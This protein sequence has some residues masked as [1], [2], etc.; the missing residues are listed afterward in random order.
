MKILVVTKKTQGVRKGDCCWCKEG[1]LVKFGFECDRDNENIDGTCGCK[2]SM[3]GIECHKAT[4]TMKVID[5]DISEDDYI[6]RIKDSLVK[7]GWGGIG[8][9]TLALAI[10]DAKELSRLANTFDVGDII[11]K[12]GDIFQERTKKRKEV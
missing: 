5:M 1:E 2:R 7:A 4:T 9:D 10:E 3:S 8:I 11:E 12:R 6:H